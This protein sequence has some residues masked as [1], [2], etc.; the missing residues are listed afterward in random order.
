MQISNEQSK[1]RERWAHDTRHIL[2]RNSRVPKAEVTAAMAS[3]TYGACFMN[4][5]AVCCKSKAKSPT[6]LK[7]N[8]ES[9]SQFMKSF[10]RR[11][12]NSKN[13]QKDP[14]EELEQANLQ[15]RRE[16]Q[17]MPMRDSRFHE[18]VYQRDKSVAPVH[19]NNAALVQTKHTAEASNN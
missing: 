12:R 17:Q 8:A 14:S 16:S 6:D 10:R 19:P 18:V 9:C 5:A 4:A 3:K 1:R 15:K 2:R 11:R 7:P 13:Q